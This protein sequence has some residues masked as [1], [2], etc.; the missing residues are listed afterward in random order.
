MLRR[1]Q[2][3]NGGTH[4]RLVVYEQDDNLAPI[5]IGGAIRA[6]DVVFNHGIPS[7]QK[8]RGPPVRSPGIQWATSCSHI[9]TSIS[10]GAMRSAGR[11]STAALSAAAAFGMPYTA[12][13]ASSCAIV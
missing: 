3:A 8:R 13:V 11:M 12:L 7:R 6:E 4:E 1:E 5:L 9:S 2:A 10:F